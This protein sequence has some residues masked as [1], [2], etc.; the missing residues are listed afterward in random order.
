MVCVRIAGATKNAGFALFAKMIRLA[1]DAAG[2]GC[3][4]KQI[5]MWSEAICGMSYL[6]RFS[7]FTSEIS[8]VFL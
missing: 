6:I 5:N 3:L 2:A 1:T 8:G 4:L 7:E